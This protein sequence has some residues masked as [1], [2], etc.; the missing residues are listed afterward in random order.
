MINNQILSNTWRIWTEYSWEVNWLE[1]PPHTWGIHRYKV[2]KLNSIRITPTHMGN[3][4]FTVNL[5]NS[6][7][8]HPHIRGEYT[9]RSLSYR[10]PQK[11][12]YPFFIK[13]QFKQHNFSIR[14]CPEIYTINQTKDYPVVKYQ[15]RWRWLFRYHIVTLSIIITNYNH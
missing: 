3:T 14:T 11:S 7:R 8:D 13:L 5:L 1:L 12:R 10:H 6:N 2:E 4:N 15:K 9:E